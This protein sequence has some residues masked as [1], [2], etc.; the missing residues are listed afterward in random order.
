[1]HVSSFQVIR[2]GIFVHLP[3]TVKKL[4][5]ILLLLFYLGHTEF[6]C[7]IEILRAYS[8]L[9][10]AFTANGARKHI[11]YRVPEI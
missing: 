7:G 10:L 9:Y 3:T 5:F 2:H 4:N 8:Q 11:A 6:G 1:M